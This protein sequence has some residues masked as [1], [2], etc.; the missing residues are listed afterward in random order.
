MTRLALVPPLL[1]GAQLAGATDSLSGRDDVRVELVDG[2]LVGRCHDR[3]VV[4]A[5]GDVRRVVLL[6]GAQT[7]RLGL[8]PRGPRSLRTAALALGTVVVLTD[9]G[10]ALVFCMPDAVAHDVAGDPWAAGLVALGKALGAPVE[11]DPTLQLD[12][13]A[14]RRVLL[15]PPPR[16]LA[17]RSSAL[18][19]AAA[20][21]AGCAAFLSEDGDR[22]GDVSL[23][24][25]VGLAGWLVAL[26][27]AE[28]RR[29]RR[30]AAGAPALADR[31]GF[32]AATS[33]PA[34]SQLQLGR[35]CVVLWSGW[36]LVRRLGP[37]ARAGVNRC[38]I[39]PDATQLCDARGVVLLDLETPE[40]LPD[41]AARAAF[42]AACAEAG[43]AV[44]E[45]SDRLSESSAQP[46]PWLGDLWTFDRHLGPDSRLGPEQDGATTF[47]TPLW[48]ALGL[49]ALALGGL[50]VGDRHGG[51]W[52]LGLGLPGRWPSCCSAPTCPSGRP[53]A[54]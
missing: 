17:A 30:G 3:E 35:A 9:S 2:R 18:V 22:W 19:A 40:L 52:W 25:G 26:L 50:V 21:A 37:T 13:A 5:A 12:R 48:T 31:V 6:T 43:I 36:R 49:G 53:G 38:V 27:V 41:D 34:Q 16:S 45:R 14:V 23:V 10:P 28:H 15:A 47:L 29:F 33:S 39:G 7:R 24:V 8:T 51:A 20:F 44:E 54:R 11:D 42:V 32:P 46:L 1:A 4:V